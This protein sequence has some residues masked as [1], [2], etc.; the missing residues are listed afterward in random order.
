[1][2]PL[3]VLVG[4][5]GAGKTSVGRALAER[6]QVGFRDT[7]AD[8]EEA[9]AKAVSDIFVEDGEAAFRELER[10]AVRRA[11]EEHDGVLALGGGAVQDPGTRELLAQH[12]V[13][14]LD[15]GLAAATDRVGFN[16]SRPLLVLNPRAELQRMLVERRPAYEEV[17]TWVVV[18]DGRDVEDVVQAIDDL[19]G[20]LS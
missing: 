5:P 7:D 20:T 4:P 12:T 13:V 1:M 6:R 17:A 2:S 9:A 16:R 3:V 11:L 19:L 8:V 15:V 18:T 10:A 14:F